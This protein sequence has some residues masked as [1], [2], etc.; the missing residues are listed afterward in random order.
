LEA[1]NSSG[2]AAVNVNSTT[3]NINVFYVDQ[4][5]EALFTVQFIGSWSTRTLPPFPLKHK[6]TEAAT[7]VSSE[8]V[9]YWNPRSGLA[10]AYSLGQDQLHVYYTGLDQ[11][12]YEFLAGYVSLQN[13]TWPAQPGRNHI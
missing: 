10:A 13:K 2:I 3:N 7:V 9:T 4:L 12:I 11:G 8:S 1:L 6:L 5:T